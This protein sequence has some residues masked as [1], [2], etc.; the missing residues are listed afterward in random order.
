MDA[1]PPAATRTTIDAMLAR[2][3]STLNRLEPIDAYSAMRK[4]AVLVDTR[5]EDLRR[6]DGWVP[7]SLSIPLSVLEWRVDPD[8]P[9]RDPALSDPEA[10]VLL[11]CAH[12]F[13]S[14]LAAARLQQLGFTRATDVVG[15]FEAWEQAGLPVDRE[16]P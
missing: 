6:R 8:S 10:H 16:E 12:G 13:S 3:R 1:P 4:G 9:H 2:A 11:I 15:G 14:S 7:G 5:A